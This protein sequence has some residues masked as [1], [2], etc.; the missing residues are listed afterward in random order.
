VRD[1]LAVM[2]GE[3]VRAAST[4]TFSMVAQSSKELGPDMKIS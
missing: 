3:K 4:K 2:N 1:A